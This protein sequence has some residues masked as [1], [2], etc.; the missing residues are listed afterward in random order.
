MLEKIECGRVFKVMVMAFREG[1][2][3]FLA[4]GAERGDRLPASSLALKKNHNHACTK[5][6]LQCCGK[7]IKLNPSLKEGILDS[8]LFFSSCFDLLKG[9]AATIKQLLYDLHFIYF[10]VIGLNAFFL[11]CYFFRISNNCFGCAI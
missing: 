1:S 7:A 9:L 2:G 4:G 8:G 3:S 5:S 11:W 6:T 10:T